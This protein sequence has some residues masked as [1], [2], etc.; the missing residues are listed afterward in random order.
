[1]GMFDGYQNLNNQYTPN[2]LCSN[3]PQP[4]C[5]NKCD[6]LEPCKPNKPYEEYDAKGE[7]V[8]YWWYQGDT[9]NLEYNIEGEV[10]VEGSSNYITAED[11]L[12][13]KQ[14]TIK[15]Y[16]FRREVIAE[17]TFEGST[18]II[19]PIDKELAKILVQGVYYSSLEIW[20]GED[21]NKTLLKQDECT[22]TIK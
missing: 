12:A 5:P 14:V 9:I 1:M 22:L 15:L 17:K 11:F 2:N 4:P 8:G 3:I 6:C 21:F 19:F 16:N 13:D 18:T 20:M 7:L 10:T